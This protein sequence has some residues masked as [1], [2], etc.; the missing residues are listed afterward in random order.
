MLSAAPWVRASLVL[1]STAVVLLSYFSLPRL[2]AWSAQGPRRMT[3]RHADPVT[4]L[5]LVRVVFS[6]PADFWTPGSRG[7]EVREARGGAP[8]QAKPW[9]IAAGHLSS[10]PLPR[11]DHAAIRPPRSTRAIPA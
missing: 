3:R 9:T 1:L 7:H 10:P 4:F 11:C 2:P 5:D 8:S 6:P